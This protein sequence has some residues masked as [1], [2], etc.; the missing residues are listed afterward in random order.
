MTF[1]PEINRT[2][3][4]IPI[5]DDSIPEHN[6]NFIVKIIPDDDDVDPGP[7]STIWIKDDGQQQNLV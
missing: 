7:S 4:T 1:T 6:K 3:I 5:I 2:Y